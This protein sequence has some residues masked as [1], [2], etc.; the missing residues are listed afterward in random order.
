LT[1]RHLQGI[2]GR[3]ENSLEDACLMRLAPF[4]LECISFHVLSA[5]F[6]VILAF[7]I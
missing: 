1:R 7:L 4:V 5:W 3:T 6:C 2:I